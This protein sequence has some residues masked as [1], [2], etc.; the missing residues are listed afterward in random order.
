MGTTKPR[1]AQIT[2][3]WRWARVRAR[4]L[5]RERRNRGQRRRR[6]RAG[7]GRARD[8]GRQRRRRERA[9]RRPRRNLARARAICTHWQCRQAAFESS[10]RQCQ[11]ELQIYCRPI[12][13]T[14]MG[15]TFIIPL[16]VVGTI[17]MAILPKSNNTDLTRV[18]KIYKF[19]HC[20][21]TTLD[22]KQHFAI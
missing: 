14:D 7:R 4:D 5:G 20:G 10:S 15:P 9:G 3:R 2:H 11:E 12:W 17:Y 21:G 13:I 18:F 19:V 8:E 6:E 22:T 1:R 16:D